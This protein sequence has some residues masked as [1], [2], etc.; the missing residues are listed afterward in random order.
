MRIVLRMCLALA[1]VAMASAMTLEL[2]SVKKIWGEA[3]HNAFG[4]LLRHNGRWWCVFREGAGHI[5]TKEDGSTDG[6]VRVLTSRNGSDWKST[7]LIAAP[8]ID[9]RDPHISVTADGRLMVVAGGSRYKGSTYLGRRPQV[10][11][12]KDGVTWSAP[13]GVLAEGEWLWR[14]TWHKGRA[15]GVTRYGSSGKEVANNPR[16][17]DLVTS[18]DGIEWTRVAPFQIPGPDETA[19]RFLDD[20]TM[21]ALT[22]RRTVEELNPVAWIG[23]A[24]PPYTEW[25]WAP[26]AVHVGGPNFIVLPDGR[27]VAGGRFY[28]DAAHK[29][30][31]TGIGEMTLTGYKP[32]LELPS[33]GDS[34]YPGFVW[35]Q[36]RLWMLYYSSHEGKTQ[37]YLAKIR[38]GTFGE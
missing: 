30:A 20:D 23:H 3:P 24:K 19:L 4:D 2:E 6:R 21:V 31:R 26:A 33:N 28:K 1:G 29:E 25:Q 14:V 15:W 11:F 35:F 13:Q 36:K 22:R 38:V 5:P 9:L 16:R 10:A 7:A 8:G 32:T 37:I 17:A 34:S 12:S 27:M 18:N